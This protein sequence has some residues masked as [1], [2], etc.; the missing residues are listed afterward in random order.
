MVG[1][2]GVMLVL[3]NAGPVGGPQGDAL[4]VPRVS[5]DGIALSPLQLGSQADE[6]AS[7]A[8]SPGGYRVFCW[9]CI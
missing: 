9:K 2:K 6:E 5:A 4:T 8:M 1:G 7:V 3:V